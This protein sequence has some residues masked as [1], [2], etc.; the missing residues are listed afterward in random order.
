LPIDIPGFQYFTYKSLRQSGT[1]DAGLLPV[2]KF[3]AA[4]AAGIKGEPCAAAYL[5]KE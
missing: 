1:E 3:K 2:A 5:C 4:I